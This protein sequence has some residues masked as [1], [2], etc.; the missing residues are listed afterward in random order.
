MGF[1]V[2]YFT[3]VEPISRPSQKIC[4]GGASCRTRGNMLLRWLKQKNTDSNACTVN[5]SGIGL[6]VRF[7]SVSRNCTSCGVLFAFH[8]LVPENLRQG[9]TY[10][11]KHDDIVITTRKRF[12]A[13]RSDVLATDFLAAGETRSAVADALAV[14]VDVMTEWPS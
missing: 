11:P 9:R 4:G 7:F 8:Y 12:I 2:W 5:L 13:K 14:A 3:L 6:D 10:D 1:S